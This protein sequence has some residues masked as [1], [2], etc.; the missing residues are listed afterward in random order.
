MIMKKVLV[1]DVGGTHTRVAIVDSKYTISKKKD[2]VTNKPIFVTLSELS[3]NVDAVCV[4]AAGPLINDSIKLTNNSLKLSQKNLEKVCKKP[5][6]LINDMVAWGNA[7][8]L[9]ISHKKIKSG[10]LTGN[11]A[12]VAIGTG[13]G[14]AVVTDKETISSEWGSV[15]W[16][17]PLDDMQL[18][19]SLKN[20]VYDDIFSGKGLL[21][22]YNSYRKKELK[23]PLNLSPLDVSS[24]TDTSIQKARAHF[25]K[26][27]VQA[28]KTITLAHLAFGGVYLSGGVLTHNPDIIKKFIKD[29]SKEKNSLIKN[30]SIYVLSD[31]DASLK[32]AAYEIYRK[33]I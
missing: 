29:I 1:A 8:R 14:L 5:V 12:I 2:I 26:Y 30:T 18:F 7:I 15:S 31:Q 3:K 4:A 33:K 25:S 21:R 24:L 28:V 17:I 32:G 13:F 11:K 9:P 22:L 23:K 6:T 19:P 27:L 16:N 20:S 10:K